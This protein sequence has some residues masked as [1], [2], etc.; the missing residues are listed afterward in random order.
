MTDFLKTL[1]NEELSRLL[2]RRARWANKA[3]VVTM[4]S[5]L[6]AWLWTPAEFVHVIHLAAVGLVVVFSVV[7]C[8]WL[9]PP[10]KELERRQ[11]SQLS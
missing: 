5:F 6:G 9:R 4:A 8:A 3:G 2:D 11:A 10:A 1:N 7:Y